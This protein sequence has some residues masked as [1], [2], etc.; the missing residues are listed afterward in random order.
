M[1]QRELFRQ[2]IEEGRV[3]HLSELANEMKYNSSLIAITRGSIQASEGDLFGMEDEGDSQTTLQESSDK[4]LSTLQNNYRI[5][6]QSDIFLMLN[7]DGYVLLN[8]GNPEHTGE[9]VMHWPIVR[10]ALKG[11]VSVSADWWYGPQWSAHLPSGK[12]DQLFGVQAFH[13][14]DQGGVYGVILLGIE[15]GP[16]YSAQFQLDQEFPS[17]LNFIK[18]GE[19]LSSPLEHQVRDD[20]KE[21]LSQSQ[22]LSRF[23]RD[24][25]L[26]LS[27]GGNDYIG[28]LTHEQDSEGAVHSLLLLK[29]FSTPLNLQLHAFLGVLYR[30]AL[31]VGVLTLIVSFLLSR[32][33]TEPVKALIQGVT[34]IGQGDFEARVKVSSGDE[35]GVLADAFNQMGEDLKTG[36]FLEG[37]MKQY[38][39]PELVDELKSTQTLESLG[40][41]KQSLSIY[42]SDVVGFTGISEMMTPEELIELL[43]RYTSSMSDIIEEHEGT[44]DKF[45]GDAIMAFWNAPKRV[46]DHPTLAARTAL[47]QQRFLKSEEA[48][49]WVKSG[50]TPLTCRIGLHLGEAIVGNVGSENRRDY[51]AIGDA[52]NLASRLEG[53]NRLYSTSIIVSEDFQA[54]LGDEFF[55]RPLDKIVVKGKTQPVVIHELMEDRDHIQQKRIDAGLRFSEML[56]VYWR[57]DFQGALSILEKA[58]DE[59]P[60]V[61]MYKKRCIQYR[62]N[63]P[64]DSWVGVTYLR[65]K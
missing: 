62:E 60:M 49:S 59:D 11:E 56:E 36:A 17:T 47:A 33:L 21:L 52:V 29:N 44:L 31:V 61:Q 38:I 9:N 40:G 53:V 58:S 22:D 2:R 50:G 20:L 19:L 18:G 13:L 34:K 45:I 35:M 37:A 6:D 10:R 46:S 15:L 57:R 32:I 55:C 39:P 16:T 1:G 7:K 12:K 42:F 43:N 28:K 51:T 41:D 48:L 63:P 4:I 25:H 3:M 65:E 5:F 14:Q 24:S 54:T 30:L 23:R 26:L 64:D 27:L 8:K